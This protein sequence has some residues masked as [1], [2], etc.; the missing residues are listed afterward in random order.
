MY[1]G[2]DGR[3]L[4]C[5]EGKYKYKWNETSDVVQ[6]TV[7]ISKFLDTSFIDVDVHPDHVIVT[8]KGKILR[9]LFDVGI[10]RELIFDIFNRNLSNQAAFCA[11]EVD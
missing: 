8:I 1:Y 2:A 10:Q 3:V 11:K 4:Q 9:L 5:N 7:E 6:L